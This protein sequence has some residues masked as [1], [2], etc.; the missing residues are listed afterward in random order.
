MFQ[1]VTPGDGG[2]P[3]LLSVSIGVS[4]LCVSVRP[5]G[6]TGGRRRERPQL[7]GPDRSV[8]LSVE[9]AGRHGGHV[10]YEEPAES[11]L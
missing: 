11:P 2:G 3:V 7:A 5:G 8:G 6:D 9:N 1:P 10:A 4:C